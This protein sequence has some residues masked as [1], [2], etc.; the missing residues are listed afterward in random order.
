MPP[1]RK[2]Q[3][4]ESDALTI[5]DLADRVGMTVRNLRE[6]RTLGLLPPAEIRGRVG[7]YDDAVVSR[8]EGIQRLQSEGFTLELIRRI[9]DASGDLG[10]EVMRLAG[11]LRAP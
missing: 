6:W 5:G 10:D 1:R 2:A 11:A 8:V 7:Y 4:S 9:L 3:Q